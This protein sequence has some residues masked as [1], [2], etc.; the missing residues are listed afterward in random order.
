M[1]NWEYW[2]FTSVPHSACPKLNLH[3]PKNFNLCLALAIFIECPFWAILWRLASNIFIAD[4]ICSFVFKTERLYKDYRLYNYIQNVLKIV[5]LFNLKNCIIK[6]NIYL[7][8]FLNHS[9]F[10]PL[11]SNWFFFM[12]LRVN[13]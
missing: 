9:S 2:N 7:F 3:I 10:P 4:A 12:L 11:A 8:K 1:S 6:N 13:I 5:N